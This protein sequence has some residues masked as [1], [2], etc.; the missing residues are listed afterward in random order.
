MIEFANLWH[1]HDPIDTVGLSESLQL[2]PEV[3]IS[4]RNGLA[5][6]TIPDARELERE[7]SS[8]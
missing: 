1:F 7:C 6:G 5:F 2:V 4:A 8:I 3:S